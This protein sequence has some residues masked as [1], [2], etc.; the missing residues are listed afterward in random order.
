MSKLALEELKNILNNDELHLALASIK[1]LDVAVDRSVLR[2]VVDILPDEVEMV[3]RMTW[4]MVGPNCGLYSFPAVGDL[5][6][7]GFMEDDEDQVYVLKRLSSQSDKIPKQAINGHIV[8]KALAGKELHLASDE[9]IL[10]GLGDPDS[11]PDEPLVLGTQLKDMLQE[12]ITAIKAITVYGNL[13][14]P[15][16]VPI[17][18]SDFTDIDDDYVDNDKILSDLA[19]TEKG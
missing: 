13:G 15:T 11:P 19:V 16:T 2:V 1:Q 8:L 10:I 12:L 6:I 3:A 4:E 7:V 5:V 17:N 14:V 18:S 9:K